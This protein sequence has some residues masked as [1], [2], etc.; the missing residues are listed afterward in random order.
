MKQIRP[1]R[2]LNKYFWKYRNL[3]F[4][5]CLWVVLSN[6]FSV[7]G[8]IYV[9][10]A[11][12]EL[13]IYLKPE[14]ASTTPTATGV[15]PIGGILLYYAALILGTAIIRGVFM[16]YMRQTLIVMSRHV[17]YDLKNEIYHKYQ[18]LD[19]AFYRSHSTGDLMN[20]ISE[21]VGRVR[22]YVGPAVLYAVNL[23]AMFAVV[24]FCMF[25]VDTELA[26]WAL[27]PLPILAVS[28][29]FVN[30]LIE[31]RSDEMQSKLSDITSFVQEAFSGLRVIKAFAKEKNI[32]QAFEGETETYRKKTMAS[33]LVDAL[34]FPAIVLL[35]GL[36]NILVIY[37]GGLKV[38]AGQ[39][40]IGNIAE[41]IIYL[42]MLAFPV[43]ALGW[44]AS[45]R[46]RAKASQIR[47]NEF[48]QT[49]PVIQSL[50][51]ESDAPFE[52]EKQIAFE[53]I[54]F[55]YAADG[56]P[57]LGPLSFVLQKG[58][59]LG[60]VGTTGSGKSTVASLLL[61]LYDTSSGQLLVDG[62][63][64]KEIN[65][66]AWR[67]QIGY[68]PQD[69]F[70]FSDSI[71][72]NIAFGSRETQ[73]QAQLEQAAKDAALWDNIEGFPKGMET[74]L[75]ERGITLSGGQKQ[76]L[77]IARAIVGN[78]EILVL[79]DCLSAVDTETEHQILANLN[80]LKQGRT[81]VII[82][83]RIS[84]VMACDEILVLENGKVAERGSHQQLLELKGRYQSLHEKQ[85]REEGIDS[86]I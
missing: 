22:M 9:R 44:V 37:V 36:S 83:H 71:A 27:A 16:Y 70:L 24:L 32:V 55:S 19:T 76:R 77:S 72:N 42:N 38:I 46:Q 64:I 75:G 40:T 3:L 31:K 50:S 65:V 63:N 45:I 15:S 33:A 49:I 84:S 80:R 62:K 81:S 29:F 48:L 13:A 67:T 85:M 73:S 6:V 21:D 35:I 34:W 10:E 14:H 53:N 52:F 41:F 59:S 8:P 82:S 57:V 61:R 12:D 54:Q 5:G 30:N 28:I 4:W 58:S 69:V 66:D 60:I 47:I 1:L 51:K 11:F 2:Q 79:D 68:V 78:P 43:T 26:L 56:K 17:E 39:I 18:G 25:A 74:M 86:V 7:F 20:R 23:V